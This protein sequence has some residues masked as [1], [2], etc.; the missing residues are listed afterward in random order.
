M[1]LAIC[2][3]FGK[4]PMGLVHAQRLRDQECDRI[5]A[6]VTEMSRVG[7][8]AEEY[9][10]GFRVWPAQDGQLHGAE[11]ETYNDH[12]MAM[13]FSVLGLKIPGIR[14]KNPS[15]VSKTF[16]NFY[17]KLKQLGAELKDANTGEK[18]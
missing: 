10:D 6:M 5:H 15:C 4:Q 16:P 3:L 13:S 9:N 14:I 2:A 18:I 7:A 11:I 12:R 8:R 17:D 1:T